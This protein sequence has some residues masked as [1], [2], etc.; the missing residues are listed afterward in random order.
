MD[1]EPA[2]GPLV[3]LGAGYAGLTV[4]SEVERRSPGSH[5]TVLVDRHPVHVLRTE[6]YELGRLAAAPEA[7]G[8][9]VPLA[10]IFDRSSVELRQGSVEAIDLPGRTVRLDSG[11]V[12]FGALAVCLGNVA[13][14]YGVPGAEEFAE[15]VYRLSRA[16]RLAERL[17]AVAAGSAGLP[18]E[19]R[20][21]VVVVGGGS[22]GTEVAAEIASTDWERIV[23]G[24]VRSPDVFLLT[25]SLPFL[26][27]LPARLVDH[28]RAQLRR[29][30][31][32]IVAGLNV[33]RLTPGQVHLEDGSVF[34]CDVAVWCAGVEAPAVLRELPVQHGSGGRIAVGPTLEIPGHPGAFA[35]G[36]AAEFRDPASGVRAPATAQAAIAEARVAAENVI[37]RRTGAP[38]RPFTYRERGILVAL[39]RRRAAASFARVTVWG[40]PAS[41]LKRAIERE[42]ARSVARGEPSGLL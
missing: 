38:L 27:G 31:V 16:R 22:T 36:D 7:G 11:P 8:W 3:I 25:G 14:Y 5:R 42:Y 30:G 10:R 19:R 23:G 28:A 26:A 32:T 2:D 20:P 18:G 21:R 41:L 4:A 6:L 17:R 37:A 15:Q 34:A 35:V 39:G 12:R 40:A 9:A 33:S 24:P 1:P 29:A 13:A